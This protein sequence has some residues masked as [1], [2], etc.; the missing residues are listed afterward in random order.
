MQNDRIAD[1]PL[2]SIN[3]KKKSQRC[4]FDYQSSSD[5]IEIVRWNDKLV[6]TIGSTAYEVQPV[7]RLNVG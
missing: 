5:E 4:V 3:E 6:V 1:Y 2:I 7:S